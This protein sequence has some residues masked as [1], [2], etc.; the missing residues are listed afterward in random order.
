MFGSKRRRAVA[1]ATDAMRPLIAIVQ[2]FKGLP[3][4]F[5]QSEYVI[6]FMGSIINLHLRFSV[7]FQLGSSERAIALGEV[8][9]NIS[10]RNGAEFIR[11]FTNLALADAGNFKIGADR[12]H[13]LIFYLMDKLKD[14]D[15]FPEVLSAKSNATDELGF[16]DK[17]RVFTN[18]LITYLIDEFPK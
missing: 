15:R 11:L 16:V 4:G 7:P 10:N 12:A 2:E 6:G 13:I 1:I 3:P 14:E 17:G 8:Y 5:W 18:L 9:Q